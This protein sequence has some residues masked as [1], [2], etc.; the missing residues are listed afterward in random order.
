MNEKVSS[1]GGLEKSEEED[2]GRTESYSRDGGSGVQFESGDCGR[3]AGGSVLR[4]MG[5]GGTANRG[6]EV[7]GQAGPHPSNRAGKKKWILKR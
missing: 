5:E 3:H 6:T 7:G 2:F 4:V 1:S